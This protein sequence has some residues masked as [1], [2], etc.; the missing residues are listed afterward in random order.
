MET[1]ILEEVKQIKK[2]LAR[3]VGT[4]NEP[5]RK[6]FSSE[7]IQKAAQ[8]FRKLEIQRGQWIIE[9]DI[10]K[11][12]RNAPYSCAKFIIERFGFKNYFKHGR[13]LYFK[14]MDLI[15]LR[16]ELKRR[17]INLRRYMELLD[18]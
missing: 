10:S 12:I 17:N 8:E 16:N 18:D 15:A 1:Q 2:L 4:Q 7:A 9:H 11:V 6:Q 5:K 13:Y 3:V 14:K